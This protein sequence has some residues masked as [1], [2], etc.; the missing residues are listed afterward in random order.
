LCHCFPVTIYKEDGKLRGFMSP[1]GSFI[2]DRQ[3]KRAFMFITKMAIAS[4][5]V[6]TTLSIYRLMNITGC[7]NS[8]V[9]KLKTISIKLDPSLWSGI[10]LKL[11][12]NGTSSMVLN[13]GRND[14]GLQSN[15]L[16]VIGSIQPHFQA[17]QGF[18][19]NAVDRDLDTKTVYNITVEGAGVYFAN[20]ILVSNCDSLSSI[21]K[22]AIKPERERQKDEQPNPADAANYEHWYRRNLGKKNSQQANQDDAY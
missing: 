11:E 5:T 4:I 20:G 18:V 13:H 3:F 1:F 17:E 16:F 21:E 6:L 19:V 8:L 7:L 12:N 15:V 10:S 22:I 9:R 14:P 2:R